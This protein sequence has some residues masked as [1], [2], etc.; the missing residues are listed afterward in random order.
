MKGGKTTRLLREME[1]FVLAKKHIAWFTPKLDTRGGSH[2]EFTALSID[3]IKQSEY[4]HCFVIEKPEE[5]FQKIAS[6]GFVEMGCIFIDEYFMIPFTRQF[7][8]DYRKSF[9]QKVPLVFAGLISSWSA[10]LFPAAIE[11]LPFM[12][13]IQK[14]DAICMECGALANYSYFNGDWKEGEVCIDNGQY[15]CLC[16]SCYMKKTKKPIHIPPKL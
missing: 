6:A 10:E 9:L 4:V 15:S 13:E 11:I 8:Y 12:D 1:K 3:K 14:E 2:N 16:H 7:F 5:I